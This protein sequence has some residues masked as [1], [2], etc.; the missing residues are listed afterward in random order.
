MGEKET[1]CKQLM[2]RAKQKSRAQQ[3]SRAR[4]MSRAQQ[5]SRVQQVSR[6]PSGA[7]NKAFLLP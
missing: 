2:S 4:K 7:P 3:M 1:N 6:A 5:R